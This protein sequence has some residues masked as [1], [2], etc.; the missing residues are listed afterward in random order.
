MDFLVQGGALWLLVALALFTIPVAFDGYRSLGVA[1]AIVFW[2]IT[3]AIGMFYLLVLDPLRDHLVYRRE[4]EPFVELRN[5]FDDTRINFESREV[6]FGQYGLALINHDNGC[7]TVVIFHG[8]NDRML[9]SFDSEENVL[10]ALDIAGKGIVD[11]TPLSELKSALLTL[12]EHD[13]PEFHKVTV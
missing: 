11:A 7:Y 1:V 5:E 2:P 4:L 8:D 3:A 6:E 9:T 13:V 12:G 10:A